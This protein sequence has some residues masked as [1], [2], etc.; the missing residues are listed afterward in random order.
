M[1]VAFLAGAQP[2][3]QRPP[4]DPSHD[5]TTADIPG[6]DAASSKCAIA[7][8]ARYGFSNDDPIQVG[9]GVAIGP[10]REVR[11]LN[12]LRGPVGQG[13]HVRRRGS[14][15]G[16]GTTIVDIYEISYAGL[17]K[18][19]TLYVDEEHWLPDPRRRKDSSAAP[20]SG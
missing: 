16:S 17:D 2:P 18:P 9:G 10:A 8:N 14:G 12:A 15:R 20:Q 7:D 13:L 19:L 5:T 1:I 11:Y 4:V 6:L 3:A